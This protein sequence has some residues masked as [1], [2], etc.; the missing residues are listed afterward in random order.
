[1]EAWTK[2]RNAICKNKY[3]RLVAKCKHA[4]IV[5]NAECESNL[6]NCNDLGRFYK[7]VSSKLSP[8]RNSPSPRNSEDKLITDTLDKANIFNQY[9]ASVFTQDNGHIPH[10][11]AKQSSSL[12]DVEFSPLRVYKA[13]KSFKPKCSFG[14]DG[15]PSILLHNTA[16]VISHPLSFIFDA[17]FRAGVL[18]TCWRDALV[19]PVFKK[20]ATSSPSN[21][22]PISLTCVC[23][24]VMERTIN[25]SIIDYL[26]MN[27]LVNAVQHG[28]L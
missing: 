10:C 22:R 2:S 19:T 27:K 25:T 18:P 5:Y 26:C 16:E 3:D 1:V 4:I 12:S 8:N 17:S 9:F 15:L 24:R 21:Y 28:F 11:K 6:V 14:P 23:S 7:F 13:L 20:G